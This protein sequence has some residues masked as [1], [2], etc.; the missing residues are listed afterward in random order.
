VIFKSRIEAGDDMLLVL[1]RRLRGGRSW[2]ETRSLLISADGCK[3]RMSH[4]L[5][6]GQAVLFSD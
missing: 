5:F 4:R 2:C 6:R 3:E 1:E